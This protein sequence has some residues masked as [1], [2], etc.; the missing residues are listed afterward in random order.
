MNKKPVLEFHNVFK[1]YG[2]DTTPFAVNDVSF[3]LEAGAFA[4]LI[5]PSGSGKTTLLNL[6]SGLD[7]PS[8]GSV[9]CD[10]DRLD[11]MNVTELTRFRAKKIGFIFQAYNLFP[12]LTA[13][14]NVEYTSLIRGD[15]A[16]VARERARAAL[17]AV[18]LSDKEQSI[19]SKLSGGQQQRVAVARALASNPSIV[20]ADEP[21]ANLD[22]V[23]AQELIDLFEKLNRELKTTF[24][25]STHDHRI[26]D[27]VRTRLFVRD[28]KLVS[29]TESE[30]HR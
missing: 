2:D 11:Q 29:P 30:K 6:A 8:R 24:V 10:G 28:G 15:G 5:G 7:Q 18:G 21:T 27:R 17:S 9:I 16:T 22:S 14:E 13:L 23:T 3:E 20:F 1:R 4:A 19:P 25:F 26:V 12:V